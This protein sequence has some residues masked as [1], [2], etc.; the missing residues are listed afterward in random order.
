M[1]DNLFQLVVTDLVGHCPHL[2]N[3]LDRGA[4]FGGRHRISHRS[5]AAASAHPFLHRDLDAGYLLGETLCPCAVS[6]WLISV[7]LASIPISRSISRTIS[8]LFMVF[9]LGIVQLPWIVSVL[10]H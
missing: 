3:L 8:L 9:I 1:P 4:A 7:G 6:L 5:A 10:G 2:L